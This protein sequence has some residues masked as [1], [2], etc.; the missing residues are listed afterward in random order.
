VNQHGVQHDNDGK[1]LLEVEKKAV[2]VSASKFNAAEA[3][4]AAL[5]APS[6]L[7]ATSQEITL[8]T[9]VSLEDAM[10]CDEPPPRDHV[11]E[12]FKLLAKHVGALLDTNEDAL[13]G[14]VDKLTR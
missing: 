3:S 14:T 6:M 12:T 5:N 2:C 9:E 1:A 11:G 10:I 8:F 7:G 13:R 4:S